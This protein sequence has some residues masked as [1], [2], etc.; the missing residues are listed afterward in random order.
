VAGVIGAVG[1]NGI[2]VSGVCWRVKIMACKALDN[3]GEGY[4]DEIIA[5]IRW[6]ADHGAKI[7][8]ISVESD[9]G[10]A[11]DTLLAQAIDYA[12]QT[13]GA[14]VVCAAGNTG[15]NVDS[16]PIWPGSLPNDNVINVANSNRADSMTYNTANGVAYLGNYGP[17]SVDLAA[18][19]EDILSLKA[20]NDYQYM[21]GTSM[22]APVVAGAAALLLARHPAF[23]YRQLKGY[24]VRYCDNLGFPVLSGGRLNVASSLAAADSGLAWDV[25]TTPAAATPTG[26]DSKG[27]GGGCFIATAAYGSPLAGEV[28]LLSLFR[29]RFL[30]GNPLGRPIVAAYY[31]LS[32]PAARY[33][34]QRAWLRPMVRATLRPVLPLAGAAMDDPL[35]LAL[36]GTLGLVAALGGIRG[37]LTARRLPPN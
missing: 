24:L 25:P 31:S 32:P 36:L 18:P 4:D 12:R 35:L 7:I 1:N 10:Q 3:I 33:I 14:L 22:A 28:R 13:T 2:G 30:L 34:A 11:E 16:N 23:D 26:S 15:I 20:G 9:P 21:S 6:A 37:R 5:A 17:A 8:N 27:G 29:D 19:G